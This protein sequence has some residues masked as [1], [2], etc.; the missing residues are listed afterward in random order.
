MTTAPA[1]SATAT[2]TCKRQKGA[3]SNAC[4]RGCS[5]IVS[6]WSRDKRQQHLLTR[7]VSLCLTVCATHTTLTHL[8]GEVYMHLWQFKSINIMRG[9]TFVS[10]EWHTSLFL[11]EMCRNISHSLSW[12]VCRKNVAI[13]QMWSVAAAA[14]PTT[15]TR[16]FSCVSLA[17]WLLFITATVRTHLLMLTHS[18]LHTNH[19][20]QCNLYYTRPMSIWWHGWHWQWQC[21]CQWLFERIRPS[22]HRK[23]PI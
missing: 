2:T 20:L 1:P 11:S 7:S 10:Q 4:L 23:I 8:L 3:N 19:V 21:Q 16:H 5:S 15:T 17:P 13:F 6:Y 14:A 18:L 22:D 12:C 9:M